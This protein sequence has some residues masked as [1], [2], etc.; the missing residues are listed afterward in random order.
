MAGIYITGIQMP[1]GEEMLCLNIHPDGK[2][3]Q[4]FDLR[5]VG[6]GRAIPVPDHGRLADMDELCKKLLSAPEARFTLEEIAWVLDCEEAAPTI[7]PAD[8]EVFGK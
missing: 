1:V 6:I 7:I 5:C 2:V 3:T 4:H 8:K